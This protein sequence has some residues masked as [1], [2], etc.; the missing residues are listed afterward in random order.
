MDNTKIELSIPEIQAIFSDLDK[1]PISAL[2][3][4]NGIKQFFEVK[5]I[6]KRKQEAESK[7]VEAVKN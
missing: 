1:M 7:Q 3:T 6:T 5:V 4:V 2:Q